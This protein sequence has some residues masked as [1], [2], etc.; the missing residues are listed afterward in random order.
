MNGPGFV[1]QFN[2]IV[3]FLEKVCSTAIR[4]H[5]R[6]RHHSSGILA[7]HAVPPGTVMLTLHR[8][9]HATENLLAPRRLTDCPAAKLRL[10]QHEKSYFFS[11]FT[12]ELYH[13]TVHFAK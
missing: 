3:V 9:L 10:L 7:K 8:H 6:F 4:A 2:A 1:V 5:D 11:I 13:S 12:N